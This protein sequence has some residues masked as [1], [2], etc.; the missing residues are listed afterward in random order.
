RR[1][2][3]SARLRSSPT[4]TSLPALQ[5]NQSLF[6][7][8]SVTL[9][10]SFLRETACS[11]TGETTPTE[12][13]RGN[14]PTIHGTRG[15]KSSP[16]ATSSVSVPSSFNSTRWP[17]S[18]AGSLGADP[19]ITEISKRWFTSPRAGWQAAR[20]R[21]WEEVSCRPRPA[22]LCT[23]TLSWDTMKWTIEQVVA[24]GTII[25]GVTGRPTYVQSD[26]GN[27]ELIV[28]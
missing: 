3:G 19:V 15:L 5:E 7:V 18:K 20:D 23:P 16:Q 17:S 2:S 25:S 22:T 14:T 10:W 12:A 26:F 4:A 28:P 11:T 6:R 8:T 13:N 27:Y 24:D 21:G 1:T 9:R